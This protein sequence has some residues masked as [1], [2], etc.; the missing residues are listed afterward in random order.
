MND[1]AA[2]HYTAIID[3]ITL[4]LQFLQARKKVKPFLT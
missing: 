2:A 4:G 3:D 1:E